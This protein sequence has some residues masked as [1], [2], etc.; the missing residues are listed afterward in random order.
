M[1]RN[2]MELSFFIIMSAQ[3]SVLYSVCILST[4]D[5]KKVTFLHIN[6]IS[7][8][9]TQCWAAEFFQKGAEVKLPSVGNKLPCHQSLCLVA[10]FGEDQA[11]LTPNSAQSRLHNSQDRKTK[12][13]CL[14]LHL[15]QDENKLA[16]LWTVLACS[17]V[18]GSHRVLNA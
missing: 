7:L 5:I 8:K 4:C 13:F 2:V 6:V 10:G 9:Q 12:S 16:V 1:K 15:T 14:R 3:Q 11:A 18:V 17:M